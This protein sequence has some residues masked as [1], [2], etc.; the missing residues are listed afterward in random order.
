[1]QQWKAGDTVQLK[2]GGPCMTVAGNATAAAGQL[3]C[4]WFVVNATAPYELKTG[5]FPGD[6]LKACEP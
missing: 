5:A 1:M 4:Q 6:S 3:L 2:S